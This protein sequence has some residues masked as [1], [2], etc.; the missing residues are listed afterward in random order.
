M[1]D[2][3]SLRMRWPRTACAAI[4]LSMSFLQAEATNAQSAVAPMPGTARIWFYRDY[5]PY[6]SRNYATVLLNGAMAGSVQ[7]YGGVIYRDVPPG[8]Y[9]LT[10]ESVG[11]DVNQDA[12]VDLAPGREA[13]VKIL[14]LPSWAS[15]GDLSPFARDT[16][17]LRLMPAAIARAEI[18]RRPF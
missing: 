2:N 16:Y 12:D 13:Y 10:V 9:H 18:A 4:V 3:C 5:E 7:P 1:L 8:H 11:Q 14:N 6:V 15:D 17:Y